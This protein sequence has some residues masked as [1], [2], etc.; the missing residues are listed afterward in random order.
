[1]PVASSTR[2]PKAFTSRPT[3][4]AITSR[5]SANTLTTAPAAALPTPNC[6]REQRQRRRDQTETQRHHEGDPGQRPYLR[7]EVAEEA[8]PS[9]LLDRKAETAG[10]QHPLHLGGALA[11]LEHLGVAV[12]AR[13][14]VLLHEAVAAEDLGGD[15]GRGDRRL[16]GVELGDGGG[17]LELAALGPPPRAWR[18][19]SRRPGRSAGGWRAA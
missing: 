16:G 7:R 1:M 10:D 6:A 12:E 15:P 18:P 14:G 2:S 17:L 13:D 4:G 8:H 9:T 19:S 5:I 11:D 3:N